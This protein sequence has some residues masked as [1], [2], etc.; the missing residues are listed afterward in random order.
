MA[1]AN[2]KKAK[3]AKK[4]PKKEAAKKVSNDELINDMVDAL[5]VIGGAGTTQL[6]GSD[7]RAIKIRGVISTQSYELDKAIGRG[8]IPTG[9]LTIIHG[10]EMSGKT[11]LALHLVAETQQRGGIV[12]YIDKEYKL[13][14]DYARKIGVNIER[15]IISQ[16]DHLERVYE[17]IDGAVTL[18]KK[19]RENTGVDVP[20]LVV[21]DSIN[22]CLSKAEYEGSF[23]AK[24]IATKARIHSQN[25]PKIIPDISKENVALL[26]IAQNRTSIGKM[27]G[28]PN[29]IAGGQA[30]K[31]Y[32]SLILNVKPGGAVKE[33]GED[34]EKVA[35][36]T[37]VTCSKNQI[38]PPFKKARFLIRHGIGIDKLASTMEK[39]IA[40][41]VFTKS[42]AKG[43]GKDTTWFKFRGAMLANGRKQLYEQLSD[44]EELLMEVLLDIGNATVAKIEG[45]TPADE[46]ESE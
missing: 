39:A 13:D 18:A 15:M 32:A 16:P 27:F 1:K 45:D 25:L 34:G 28:D 30:V 14:P 46:D 24:H 35:Q 10:P 23:E 4:K 2:P 43:S 19:W 41:K 20:V 7:G 5:S 26:F 33:G 37:V 21:L 22:A 42:K 11:T 40:L 3:K 12:V 29:E 36:K 44:D 8:G 9:R 31:Y 38:S 6:L 17:L